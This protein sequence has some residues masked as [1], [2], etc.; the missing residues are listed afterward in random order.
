MKKN[1]TDCETCLVKLLILIRWFRV[2]SGIIRHLGG[3]GI[4]RLGSVAGEDG[5]NLIKSEVGTGETET[6][7]SRK[8]DGFLPHLPLSPFMNSSAAFT[9]WALL[10]FLRE[11]RIRHSLFTLKFLAFWLIVTANLSLFFSLFQRQRWPKFTKLQFFLCFSVFVKDRNFLF[12]FFVLFDSCLNTLRR[13]ESRR[14][15]IFIFIFLSW[16]WIL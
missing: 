8:L 6:G 2:S 3:R 11:H 13:W 7:K 4:F 12:V 16:S 5:R 1:R 14:N 10:P 15:W 9:C